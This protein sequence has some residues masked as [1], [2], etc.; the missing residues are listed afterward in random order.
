MALIREEQAR[1]FNEQKA[2]E[3]AKELLTHLNSL[4]N[5]FHSSKFPKDKSEDI[6]ASMESTNQ[7][8]TS[9]IELQHEVDELIKKWNSIESDLTLLSRAMK[10]LSLATG[11]SSGLE[12]SFEHDL[13]QFFKYLSVLQ[14]HLN[15]VMLHLN[16]RDEERRYHDKSIIGEVNVLQEGLQYIMTQLSEEQL[17]DVDE[18]TASSVTTAAINTI[19]TAEGDEDINQFNPFFEL[20]N[21]IM[22]HILS[23]VPPKDLLNA[24]G[25]A[26]SKT[27]VVDATLEILTRPHFIIDYLSHADRITGNQFT[28]FYQRTQ[29]YQE[30]KRKVLANESLT[31]EEAICY[32]LSRDCN[33]LP[34]NL[35]QAMD[36]VTLEETTKK[37]LTWIISTSEILRRISDKTETWEVQRYRSQLW[38]RLHSELY[39][40]KHQHQQHLHSQFFNLFAGGDLGQLRLK[41][42]DFSHLNL[43]G[44]KFYGSDLSGA[45]FRGAYLEGADFNG[46]ILDEADFTDAEFRG[47][48]LNGTSLDKFDLSTINLEE[49]D[50]EWALIGHS[51]LLPSGTLN[52]PEELHT[53]LNRFEKSIAKHSLRSKRNLEE[54]IL[55]EI[56]NAIEAD[57]RLS[58]KEKIALLDIALAEIKQKDTIVGIFP[59]QNACQE[60]KEKYISPPKQDTPAHPLKKK[61]Q[62]IVERILSAIHGFDM[63]TGEK[64]S[65]KS[66][67]QSRNQAYERE[68]K[69][70]I[71][72]IAKYPE[73]ND[74]I[75]VAKALGISLEMWHMLYFMSPNSRNTPKQ[76]PILMDCTF[77]SQETNENKEKHYASEVFNGH[78]FDIQQLQEI[79]LD[80]LEH[81]LYE[82][83]D[84][85]ILNDN[86]YTK[87]RVKL[88]DLFITIDR[89]E[90]YFATIEVID[91]EKCERK[92]AFSVSVLHN[93]SIPLEAFVPLELRSFYG[94]DIIPYRSPNSNHARSI[95]EAYALKKHII[96]RVFTSEK[97]YRN[98]KKNVF[99]PIFEQHEEQETSQLGALPEQLLDRVCAYVY[100]NS[101]KERK[102]T[103]SPLAEIS[104]LHGLFFA[105]KNNQGQ[106]KSHKAAPNPSE[107]GKEKEASNKENRQPTPSKLAAPKEQG[108]FSRTQKEVAQKSA[109]LVQ[110]T[111]NCLIS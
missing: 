15:E 44:I 105:E 6:Y 73:L 74:G 70:L 27:A 98:H 17:N 94:D 86:P 12:S 82:K 58:L 108:L 29:R 75:K 62:K 48:Q 38:F 76:F 54:Q 90:G 89:Y 63:D 42:L 30:L 33:V 87:L 104:E 106:T 50:F 68:Y 47:I 9:V 84:F 93:E 64:I 59:F 77:P 88:G 103:A 109:E 36:E 21:E 102:N 97:I 34:A 43:R 23:H 79:K 25:M 45:N 80:E 52:S 92:P 37:N 24:R 41:N 83:E 78:I 8:V 11:K 5:F 81:Y 1:K 18:M 85:V 96:E 7:Y 66:V 49:I 91:F 10:E 61:T 71:Q 2:K 95:Q 46:A 13:T 101:F 22:M 65:D 35:K 55:K 60:L 31:P 56:A 20:P 4:N 14:E 40:P 16:D 26:K 110:S 99:F 111:Q 39:R 53:F 51:R 67:N 19:D 107:K 72:W 57:T 32:T 100:A 69:Q 3:E 28:A